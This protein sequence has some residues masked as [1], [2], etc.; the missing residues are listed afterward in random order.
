MALT[1]RWLCRGTISH[2]LRLAGGLAVGAACALALAWF[3]D[4]LIR[5]SDMVLDES[6]RNH[7]LEFVRIKRE[8]TVERKDR[9]PPKPQ[10]QDTPEVPP[11]PQ[12]SLDASGQPTRRL[13][14]ARRCGTEY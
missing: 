5:T 3:M 4:Y 10:L 1:G 12:D 8:E 14:D 2:Y 7:M 13:G 11:T 9:K 6:A